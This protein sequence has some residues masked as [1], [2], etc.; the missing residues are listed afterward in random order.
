I[1]RLKQ[2]RTLLGTHLNPHDCWML[3]RSLETMHLRTERAGRNAM[4]IA[5]FLRDHPKVASVTYLG[6]IA[7]GDGPGAAAFA[8]QCR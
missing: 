8:R 3:L 2:L 4:A 5:A 6:F 7:T 1:G